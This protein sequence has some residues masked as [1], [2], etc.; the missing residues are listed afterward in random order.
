[1]DH[2]INKILSIHVCKFQLKTATYGVGRRL[3]LMKRR[4]V[5]GFK[6]RQTNCGTVINPYPFSH[7]QQYNNKKWENIQTVTGFYKNRNTP[8]LC[9]TWT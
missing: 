4:Q 9:Y 6:E 2:V 1:M 7:P 3:R 8:M 5:G